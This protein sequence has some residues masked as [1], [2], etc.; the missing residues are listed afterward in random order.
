MNNKKLRYLGLF[1]TEEEA[2]RAYDKAAIR[3][4]APALAISPTG[5]KMTCTVSY[6]M[7]NDAETCR[8]HAQPAYAGPA[9]PN[10]SPLER[11]VA[12]SS[13]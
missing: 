4:E 5:L 9:L 8:P 1:D 12:H 7:M 3:C 10:P 11:S 2:A 13:V 6:K